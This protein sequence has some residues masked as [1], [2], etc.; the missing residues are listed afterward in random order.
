[1]KRVLIME[2]NMSLAFDWKDAFE[3]NN[4]EVTLAYKGEEASAHLEHT[5]FDIVVTDMFVSKGKGGLH[6]IGKL[7]T[8]GEKAPPVIA[9]TG[10][11]SEMYTTKKTNH[12]L[13][14][15]RRLGASTSLEKPFTP[16]ELVL[17]ANKLLD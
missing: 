1:M 12:F 17:L 15:A 6:V 5:Q 16:V 9:V 2:D 14:Q 13:E 3:L 4:F 8:M 7:A 11:K 10:A